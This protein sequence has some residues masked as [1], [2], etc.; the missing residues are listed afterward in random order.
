M[1]HHLIFIDQKPY[2]ISF[3]EYIIL[4]LVIKLISFSIK[5]INQF[6]WGCQV[7]GCVVITLEILSFLEG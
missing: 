5:H 4:Y 1:N 7:V 3:I 6:I 2:K